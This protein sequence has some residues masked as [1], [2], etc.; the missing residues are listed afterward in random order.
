MPPSSPADPASNGLSSGESGPTQSDT[1]VQYKMLLARSTTIMKNVELDRWFGALQACNYFRR[2]PTRELLKFTQEMTHSLD[3]Q[4]CVGYIQP[5]GSRMLYLTDIIKEN[6]SKSLLPFQEEV[7]ALVARAHAFE[8]NSNEAKKYILQH[9]ETKGSH[10][11]VSQDHFDKSHFYQVLTIIVVSLKIIVSW[12]YSLSFLLQSSY[13]RWKR[14]VLT[15]GVGKFL[16]DKKLDGLLQSM[17]KDGD[18]T[19]FMD[20]SR[21]HFC[22]PREYK[23]DYPLDFLVAA[24]IGN[25]HYRTAKDFIEKLHRGGKSCSASLVVAT[26]RGL[27]AECNGLPDNLL[28]EQIAAISQ[29]PTVGPA[30]GSKQGSSS[31]DPEAPARGFSEDPVSR[32]LTDQPPHKRTHRDMWTA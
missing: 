6:A 20:W 19:S 11:I 24:F 28:L 1:L 22:T 12:E 25:G 26:I 17:V 29:P 10:K 16:V 5:W 31:V 18:F 30:S 21:W 15:G 7:E 23:D 4:V 3:M 8:G 32:L 2:M 27:L 14:T 9:M 13:L